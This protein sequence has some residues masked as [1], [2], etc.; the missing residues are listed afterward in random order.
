MIIEDEYKDSRQRQYPSCVKGHVPC[1]MLAAVRVRLKGSQD[2][3]LSKHR[4]EAIVVN[5]L[6]PDFPEPNDGSIYRIEGRI[7]TF[8]RYENI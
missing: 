1:V 7:E 3:K 8:M 2:V 4:S 5:G 6:E